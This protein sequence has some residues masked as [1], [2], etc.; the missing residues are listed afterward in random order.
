AWDSYPSRRPESSPGATPDPTPRRRPADTPVVA[1]AVSN[2]GG[3]M[4]RAKPPNLAARMG[5]WSASH[6]KT[7]TFGWLALVIVAFRVYNA[8]G[9]NKVDPSTAGPGESGRVDRILNDGFKQPAAEKVV[10]QSRSLRAGDPA[11][12]AAV[13]DVVARVSKVTVVENINRGPVSKDRHT[14]LLDFPIPAAPNKPPP[15]SAAPLDPPP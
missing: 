12:D 13:N 15:N 7:A 6:W 1:S 4:S 8:G 11:F 10:V 9:R 3:S 14:A 2:E 5:R